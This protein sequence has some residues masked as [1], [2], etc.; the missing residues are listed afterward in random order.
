MRLFSFAQQLSNSAS[1]NLDENWSI[2][3]ASHSI[4]GTPRQRWRSD[5]GEGGGGQV[6]NQSPQALTTNSLASIEWLKWST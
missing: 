5:R 2:V 1:D 6:A 4:L 3:L